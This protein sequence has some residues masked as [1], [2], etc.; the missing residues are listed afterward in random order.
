MHAVINYKYFAD[1]CCRFFIDCLNNGLFTYRLGSDI[2]ECCCMYLKHIIDVYIVP[3]N[4]AES[5]Q[6]NKILHS[7][8]L[9]AIIRFLNEESIEM[10][11]G[12]FASLAFVGNFTY[13]TY[14]PG[15]ESLF[16]R[17]EDMVKCIEGLKSL[18]AFVEDFE[19]KELSL[20]TKV[21]LDKVQNGERVS[22]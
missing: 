16:F 21:R 1:D 18:K 20:I 5:L 10:P 14:Y 3:E 17:P 22:V 7:R 11:D 15:P 2:Q 6:K 19:E 12:L 13:K 4:E 8:N 9:S